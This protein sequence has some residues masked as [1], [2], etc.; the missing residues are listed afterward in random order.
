MR[1]KK[2]ITISLAAL[3]TLGTPLSVLADLW[4]VGQGSITIEAR[5]DGQ[6]VSQNDT[7]VMDEAPTVTGTT[8]ENT[9]TIIADANQ[10]ADVTISDLEI[11][12][13]E[14]GNSG[15]ITTEGEG[16]VTITIEGE[17]HVS[18]SEYHAGVEK[19]NDGSLTINGSEDDSLT[20][21]GGAGG[22]GIGGAAGEAVSDITINGG[23]IY[24]EATNDV[25]GSG[26]GIGGGG[27]RIIRNEETGELE[28]VSGGDGSNITINGGNVT[29]VG[30]VYGSGIGGGSGNGTNITINNGIV[31]AT[32][33]ANG[34]GIGGGDASN[35]IINGGEVT[36][37]GTGD[38]STQNNGGSGIGGSTGGNGENI[39]INGGKVK[40]SAE[41]GAAAIGGGR[42][43]DG[44]NITITGGEVYAEVTPSDNL[45]FGAAIGGGAGMM[46][47]GGNAEN[48]TISGGS[49]TAIVKGNGTAIGGGTN[50][51][52]RDDCG[53]ASNIVISGNAKVTV[54][55]IG[56]IGIGTGGTR[57]W[58]DNQAEFF[59]GEEITPDTSKLTS[60]GSIT[61]Y[62][63]SA[64]PEGKTPVKTIVGSYVPPVDAPANRYY[65]T[66]ENGNA[67]SSKMN[68]SE[69]TITIT[70][71]IPEDASGEK[72]VKCFVTR[73]SLM[74]LAAQG[75]R[76]IHLVTPKGI[77]KV[78]IAD[79]LANAGT[80]F[81]FVVF[82][83]SVVLIADEAID[84]SEL[85]TQ[86][87]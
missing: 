33:K 64:D 18:G 53:K 68:I 36:A 21:I 62:D 77:F 49:V 61:Y 47:T 57:D 8:G 6:W 86:D 20:A 39:T 65:V 74:Q 1:L 83:D 28:F 4:D 71:D 27:T 31:N 51:A 43:G 3:L 85:I 54:D 13:A 15:A 87:K 67:L 7:T 81:C 41:A 76:E 17:N 19:S 2:V 48:I 80:N 63:R 32:G 60:D 66:D 50:V 45:G 82:G 12:V 30:G 38:S 56:G 23:T 79:L 58:H 11:T 14:D 42:A 9:L 35:I 22:A 5:E 46:L 26:A 70:L 59:P 37:I 78:K 34:A 69:G 25:R 75:I 16:N 40:A 72:A 52:G 73:E 24:A 29:A 44:K 84:L 55:T 10:T